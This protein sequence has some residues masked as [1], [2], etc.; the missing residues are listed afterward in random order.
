MRERI[1]FKYVSTRL[2]LDI[3]FIVSPTVSSFPYRIFTIIPELECQFKNFRGPPS[4]RASPV[5]D[6]TFCGFHRQKIP[7]EILYSSN[8]RLQR[9]RQPLPWRQ[10]AACMVR[11]ARAGLKDDADPAVQPST[12]QL[13]SRIWNVYGWGGCST[14]RNI[15]LV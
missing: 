5:T 4:H 13:L 10:R 2:F 9:T 11:R 8:R 1:I 14:K 15:R 7:R 6:V 12:Q 3:R